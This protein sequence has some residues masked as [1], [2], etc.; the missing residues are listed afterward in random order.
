MANRNSGLARAP[1]GDRAPCVQSSTTKWGPQALG[2]P[3]Q[4]P[5]HRDS[6][7]ATKIV[8]DSLDMSIWCPENI[9]RGIIPRASL[10]QLPLAVL[11]FQKK[12]AWVWGV[13]FP[14][15]SDRVAETFTK[16][17]ASQDTDPDEADEADLLK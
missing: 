5:P 6:I 14:S 9:F 15:Q 7:T 17:G 13:P 12:G 16:N 8:G 2:H 1:L 10:D 11:G 3:P 4:A